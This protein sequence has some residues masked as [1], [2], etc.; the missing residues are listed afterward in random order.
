MGDQYEPSL[1]RL[2]V[3]RLHGAMLRVGLR[4][5]RF[6][7]VVAAIVGW[8]FLLIGIALSGFAWFPVTGTVLD[9]WIW[10]AVPVVVTL[11][12]GT[13]ARALRR[14]RHGSNPPTRVRTPFEVVALGFCAW[15]G[16]F[17]I[18]LLVASL[19]G[20]EHVSGGFVFFVVV[21]ATALVLCAVD[22]YRYVTK[23]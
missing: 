11:A 7:D 2:I 9:F 4:F 1:V 20:G 3:A 6:T 18:A 12:V 19:S 15:F 16:L 5:E 14:R 23:E 13:L 8:L 17:M 10:L 22:L 21:G